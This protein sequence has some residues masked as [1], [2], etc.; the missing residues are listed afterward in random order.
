[1]T[2]SILAKD[3]ARYEH[4]GATN[5]REAKHELRWT[6]ARNEKRSM[7]LAFIDVWR[8]A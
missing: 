5:V 7:A 8:V 1:M 2:L 4:P 6:N 3:G